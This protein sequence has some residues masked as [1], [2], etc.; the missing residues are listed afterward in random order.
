MCEILFDKNVTKE[1]LQKLNIFIGKDCKI[2]KNVK[3]STGVKILGKSEICDN[4]CL[5]INSVVKNSKLSSGVDV[6]SSFVEDS[7]IGES[8]TIGPF[9]TLKKNSVVGNECRIGN[10]V[11]IK[12]SNIGNGVKIAHLTYVG[13]ADIGDG[14]NL[15]CGVV[16][17]NYDG[18]K[19]RR[20]IVEENVFIGSNVNIVAPLRIERDSY[21]AAGST[22]NKDIKCGQLAIARARQENKNNFKNPYLK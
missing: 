3:I 18:E 9:A 20:S 22:I 14:C 15:G 21:I 2:G 8:T 11:E 17:C 19:K 4:C 6:V 7:I 1:Q 5:G 13:D 16:F 10:F 12:N